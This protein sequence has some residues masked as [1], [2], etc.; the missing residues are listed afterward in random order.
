MHRIPFHSSSKTLT[1]PVLWADS[2]N[3]VKTVHTCCFLFWFGGRGVELFF[4]CFFFVLF[5]FFWGGGCFL[6]VFCFG[7]GLGFCFCLFFFGTIA[8]GRKRAK[9]KEKVLIVLFFLLIRKI[10]KRRREK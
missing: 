2:D 6:G 3:Y 8:I 10:L 4:V 9:K 5:F 7:F 1:Q